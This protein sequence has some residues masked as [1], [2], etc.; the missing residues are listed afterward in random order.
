MPAVA[1]RR[2][3]FTLIELLVVIAIIAIL[4]GLLL[5]AVQKVRDAAS[6]TQCTN[7][8]KQIGIALQ[9]YHDTY[10][11]FPQG[12]RDYYG[13]QKAPDDYKWLSWMGRIL[14]YVEQKGL[15]DNMVAA[16]ASQGGGAAGNPQVNPP[17]AGF[18]TVINT[19]KCTADTRQY[20]ATY[21]GGYTV[22]FCGYLGVNGTDLRAY[23]GVLYWNSNIRIADVK[24]GLSNTLFV[25]ERPPSADL[26]FGWWYSGGGQWDYN[27][28]LLLNLG[29]SIR[30]TGSCDITLGLAEKNIATSGIP[31]T[32]ACPAGPYRFSPG[33]ITN[34][35]D[36]F[37]FWSV[38][39]GGSNFL[40]GDGS[41]RFINY[42]AAN[43]LTAMSTR[44]GGEPTTL[45]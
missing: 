9:A 40:L 8:L 18:A 43:V 11:V 37:H 22:A 2:P 31:A 42:D 26:Y 23:D 28:T 17:H 32:D 15:Y 19:Y 20:Q 10:Q 36:Q 4:I 44:A 41:V 21:T 45:P 3:A 7:N 39:A 35:C 16:Y 33:T 12:T 34:P 27:P 5:P 25:G 13:G 1:R 14:P 38:H 24:D 6:R 29:T 30:N